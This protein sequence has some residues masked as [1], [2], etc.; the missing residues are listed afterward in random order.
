VAV[1]LAPVTGEVR[2]AG[3]G[4]EC[5]TVRSAA[6]ILALQRIRQVRVKTPPSVLIAGNPPVVLR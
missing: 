1:L 4:P 2:R 3:A 5:V 6:M